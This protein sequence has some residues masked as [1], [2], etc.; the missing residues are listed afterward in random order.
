MLLPYTHDSHI[1]SRPLVQCWPNLGVIRAQ[2]NVKQERSGQAKVIWPLREHIWP[3]YLQSVINTHLVWCFEG[4][5][6]ISEGMWGHEMEYLPWTEAPASASGPDKFCFDMA[7]QVTWPSAF[8]TQLTRHLATHIVPYILS[9]HAILKFLIARQ[10]CH[11]E[12]R[13]RIQ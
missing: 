10:R 7:L 8:L 12:N 1:N 11:C 13:T 9:I 2:D 3:F 4:Y 5:L 6:S